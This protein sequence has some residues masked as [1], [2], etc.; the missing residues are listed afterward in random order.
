VALVLVNVVLD[1]YA[2][3]CSQFAA[4]CVLH[5]DVGL[6]CRTWPIM[7]HDKLKLLCLPTIVAL[8]TSGSR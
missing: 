8:A 4:I 7:Q 3:I 6:R 5:E 1:G 2:D